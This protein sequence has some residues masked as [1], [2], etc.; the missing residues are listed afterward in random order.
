MKEMDSVK[1]PSD[2]PSL[3]DG[4]IPRPESFCQE[5]K[6]KRKQEWESHR[7]ALEK[8][9]ESKEQ[10]HHQQS[11]EERDAMYVQMLQNL[12][13]TRAAVRS[14][15]SKASTIS[16]EEHWLAL[17]EDD[18]L[19]IQQKMDRIDQ[20]LADQYENWQA[21]YRNAVTSEEC[22]KVKRFYKSYWEKYESKYRILYQML[23]QANRQ[24]GQAG[25]LSNQEPTSMI[26]P[27]L[28]ALDDA[29]TLRKKEWKRG[30]PGEDV[31]RQYSTVCGHLTSTQPRHEDMRMDSTL[32]VT[33]EGSLH[34]LPAAVGGAVDS[35][36][37]QKAQQVP[38]NEIRGVHPSTTI[39]TSTDESPIPL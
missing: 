22:E 8:T 24:M 18:F 29:Q 5:R 25:L 4:M 30:E 16:D 33:P 15:I 11:Q 7:V 31:P 17:M 32:N 36:R 10:Q 1:L 39:V 27:S 9:K 21:E 3:E 14:S 20:K 6:D 12:E 35:R 34:D 13:R 23:Q 28:A 37:E 19:A 38:E 26:T 2:I